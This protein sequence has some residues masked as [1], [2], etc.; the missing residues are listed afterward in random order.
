MNIVLIGVG[1]LG[2]FLIQNFFEVELKK[3]AKIF[4]SIIIFDSDIVEERNLEYT[5]YNKSDV[6]VPKVE[7]VKRKYG[8]E[9]NI[10]GFFEKYFGQEFPHCSMVISAVDSMSSRKNIWFQAAYR[11][12]EKVIFFFDGRVSFDTFR[13]YSINP[14][15][16]EER[17][18]YE[19]TLYSDNEARFEPC[20]MRNK[21]SF[22][23]C[24]KKIL[25]NMDYSIKHKKTAE[26]EFIFDVKLNEVLVKN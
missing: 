12:R 8:N 14:N 18:F 17:S 19:K 15:I 11:Q 6:L 9:F 25:K 26:K 24:A 22:E 4:E 3:L 20:G 16:V 13:V 1:A 21:S 5:A 23:K 10:N 2:S 7:A